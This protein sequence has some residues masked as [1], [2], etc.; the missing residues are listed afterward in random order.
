MAGRTTTT[1]AV[2]MPPGDAAAVRAVAAR[3]GRP[4]ASLLL[5]G[6]GL[7]PSPPELPPPDFGTELRAAVA[8]L[9]AAV[10]GLRTDV[11]RI[12]ADVGELWPAE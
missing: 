1:V 5:A 7:D 8:E 9:R 10:K 4:L 12:D 11:D 2:R 6:A 3:T